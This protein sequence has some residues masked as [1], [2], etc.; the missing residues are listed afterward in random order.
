M[1]ADLQ[2]ILNVHHFP[3]RDDAFAKRIRR[4]VERMRLLGRMLRGGATA[5]A[6]IGCALIGAAFAAETLSAL[7]PLG[8]VPGMGIWPCL[9]LAAAAVH[10][11][12][13]LAAGRA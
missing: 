11:V 1:T 9:I 5:A 7:A 12:A 2:D 4:R 8:D 3:A 10:V 6:V 13:V